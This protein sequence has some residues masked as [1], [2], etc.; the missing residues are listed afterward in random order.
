MFVR[1]SLIIATI[2]FLGVSLA[3]GR[4]YFINESNWEGYSESYV[5]YAEKQMDVYINEIIRSM[6]YGIESH[7]NWTDALLHIREGDGPW[8]GENATTYIVEDGLFETDY[9]LVTNEELSYIQESGGSYKEA[10]LKNNRIKETLQNDSVNIFHMK[11]DNTPAI[12]VSAPFSDNEQRVSEG[13]YVCVALFDDERMNEVA[14]RLG[15]NLV[16]LIV[17]GEETAKSLENNPKSTVL[18]TRHEILDSGQ[19]IVVKVDAKDV[20]DLFYNQRDQVI[21]IIIISASL[22]GICIVAFIYVVVNRLK[23]LTGVIKNISEGEYDEADSLEIHANT[24]E[25]DELATAVKKMSKDIDQ[26]YIEM[27]NIIINAVEINDIYTSQHNIEVGHYSKIIAEEINYENIDDIT[28]AAKLHDIGKISVPG[29]ILNKRGKLTDEE[30]EYI[31]IHPVKGYK[32]I[33]NIDYF[34]D[35]RLGVKYH[36]EHWDGSGYPEGLKGDE[37]PIVAQ[38]ISIADVYD[39]LTSDRSYREAM[40]HDE[41]VEIIKGGSGTFFNPKLVE[42]FLRREED[43]R[44]LYLENKSRRGK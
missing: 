37:I 30:Y 26:N 10:L 39:A 6:K 28:M 17:E 2:I 5:K 36:H 40:V 1:Y 43:F 35:V 21:F 25:L 24:P 14:D 38:I 11:L 44:L 13:A 12:I 15:N 27:V 16:S 20:H 9:I 34:K 4:I 32:I 18:V 29:Y 22:I 41:A 19:Y 8:L 3:V 23:Q 31:K 7:A 42:A 33:E